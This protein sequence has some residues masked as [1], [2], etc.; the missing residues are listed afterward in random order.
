MAGYGDKRTRSNSFSWTA[1]LLYFATGLHSVRFVYVQQ[2]L[3]QVSSHCYVC[4]LK[5]NESE[6]PFVNSPTIDKV[7]EFSL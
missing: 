4:V 1:F 2:P 7:M 5:H 6:E 3:V